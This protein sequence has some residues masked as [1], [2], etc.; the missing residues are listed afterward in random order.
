MAKKRR[1]P[2]RPFKPGQSGNPK[3]KPR[4]PEQTKK[5]RAINKDK[6]AI[7]L[8]KY[9]NHTLAELEKVANDPATGALELIVI[10]AIS[11]A[12]QKGDSRAREFI[13]ERMVGRV[14]VELDVEADMN[15]NHSGQV[16]VDVTHNF[17]EMLLDDIEEI[18]K[19]NAEEKQRIA[20][21]RPQLANEQS[22]QDSD[23]SWGTIDLQ[24]EFDSEDS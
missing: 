3:G 2:G 18:E 13:V 24:T 1:G 19:K 15:M 11:D 16:D 21:T 7:M 23:E 17:R 6:L 8:N 20:D 14:P 12:I 4:L 5:L 22:V 10:S 9:A